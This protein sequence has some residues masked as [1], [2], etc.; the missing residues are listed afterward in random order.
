M[1]KI[2]SSIV[3]VLVWMLVHSKVIQESNWVAILTL[4]LIILKY[5]KYRDIELL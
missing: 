3:D 4:T 2:K 1:V 5:H